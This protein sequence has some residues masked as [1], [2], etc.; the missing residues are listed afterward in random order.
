MRARDKRADWYA[1]VQPPLRPS[2]EELR[3][4]RQAM[5]RHV[6]KRPTGPWRALLLGVT[7]GLAT[8]DWPDSTKLLAADYSLATIEGVWPR[9]VPGVPSKGTR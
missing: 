8:L 4:I 3:L 9:D 7:P 1:L 5:D 2:P 6:L